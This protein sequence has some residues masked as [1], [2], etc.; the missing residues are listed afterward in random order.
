MTLDEPPSWAALRRP[1]RG[2]SAVAASAPKRARELVIPART[3]PANVASLMPSCHANAAIV[4]PL[5]RNAWT[6]FARL[7][8]G[9][10]RRPRVSRFSPVSTNSVRILAGSLTDILPAFNPA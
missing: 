4:T 3:Q 1:A 7:S 9:A 8:G 5:A 10:T 2:S 6:M